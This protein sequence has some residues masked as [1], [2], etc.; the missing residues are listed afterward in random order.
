MSELIEFMFAW[1]AEDKV[2]WTDPAVADPA[3]DNAA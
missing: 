3:R 1:G 2:R